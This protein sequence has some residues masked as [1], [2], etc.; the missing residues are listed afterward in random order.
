MFLNAKGGCGKTTL[1]REF[2]GV[3][4]EQGKSTLVID[5]DHLANLTTWFGLQYAPAGTASVDALMSYDR[6][7]VSSFIYPLKFP[8]IFLLPSNTEVSQ[9]AKQIDLKV[10][11]NNTDNGDKYLPY[12]YLRKLLEKIGSYDY[13]FIDCPPDLHSPLTYNALFAGQHIIIP[14][15]GTD[16]GS[17]AGVMAIKNQ[18]EGLKSISPEIA[19]IL[20]IVILQPPQRRFN[21]SH[22]SNDFIKE[23]REA[24]IHQFQTT[25]RHT[26]R[27]N[28]AKLVAP[29]VTVYPTENVTNDFRMLW[30]EVTHYGKF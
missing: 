15:F 10:Q 5:F 30:K 2:A 16:W 23:I 4:S 29:L 26:E 21:I 8:N 13:I 7:D 14:M 22:S 19:K 25:I 6:P 17:F 28:E 24:G 27:V 9:V 20:G 1:T 3:I 18:I 11:L 12:F